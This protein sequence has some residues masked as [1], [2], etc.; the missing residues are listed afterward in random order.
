MLQTLSAA[1]STFAA[2]LISNLHPE[3]LLQTSP[4]GYNTRSL[5]D[6][7]MDWLVIRVDSNKGNPFFLYLDGHDSHWD[8]K[9]HTKA[10]ENYIFV[11]FLRSNASITD[12]ANDNGFNASFKGAYSRQ[13]AMWTRTYGQG[14]PFTKA[15]Q[16][17]VITNAY[18]ELKNSVKVK[19]IIKDAFMKTRCFPLTLC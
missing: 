7:W 5:F 10:R 4:T 14:T 18:L 1:E 17:Q 2:N 19:E 11:I 9:M 3:F 6:E 8:H 12:Q 13:Y 16:N 15:F